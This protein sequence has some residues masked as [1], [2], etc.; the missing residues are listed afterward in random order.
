[1]EIS[2]YP[3]IK[4]ISVIFHGYWKEGVLLVG[5][6]CNTYTRIVF[7]RSSLTLLTFDFRLVY[8]S[9]TLVLFKNSLFDLC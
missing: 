4:S 2:F 1:M 7:F 6:S 8:F 3:K 9:P 5:V